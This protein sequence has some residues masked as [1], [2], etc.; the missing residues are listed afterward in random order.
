MFVLRLTLNN[1]ALKKY[2]ETSVLAERQYNFKISALNVHGE[3]P[4]S[5]AINLIAAEL[6]EAPTE[7][8]LVR[9]DSE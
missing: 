6:P 4:L 2:T 3:G 9:A 8:K 7:I 5:D 1:S